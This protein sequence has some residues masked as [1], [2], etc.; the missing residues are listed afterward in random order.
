MGRI[1]KQKREMIMEANRRL[2]NESGPLNI[3][4]G[5]TISLKC[6]SEDSGRSIDIDG[7]VDLE[8][9]DNSGGYSD[10]GIYTDNEELIP[11]FFV[12]R[13]RGL[14]GGVLEGQDQTFGINIKKIDEPELTS[15]AGGGSLLV[16]F[17]SYSN[18]YFCKVINVTTQ[19]GGELRDH[20]VKV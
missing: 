6:S 19:F 16:Y 20:G 14:D 9:R 4:E 3:S 17:D 12:V 7:R 2:L 15:T 11:Q 10:G 1:G 18:K 13:E 5:Q 8:S